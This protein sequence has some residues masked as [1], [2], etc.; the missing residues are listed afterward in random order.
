MN[1]DLTNYFILYA[2]CIPVKGF[3]N[4]IICDVQRGSFKFIPSS[5]FELLQDSKGKTLKTI[6]SEYSREEHE[7]LYEYYDFLIE[8]EFG[9]LTA[10][11]ELFPSITLNYET[12]FLI[13]NAIIDCNCTSSHDFSA[14]FGQ[15]NYLGCKSVQLRFFDTETIDSLQNTIRLASGFTFSIELL[16]KYDTSF[17]QEYLDL[18]QQNERVSSITVHTAD[19]DEILVRG[20]HGVGELLFVKQVIDSAQHCGQI[21]PFL[22]SVNIETFTEAQAFNSCLNKKISIDV[23]GYIRN[24]PSMKS[25]YGHTNDTLLSTVILNDQFT[26]CWT[27]PKDE[28]ESCRDCEFRYICTDCRAFT[29]NP[30]NPYSKP[31][32]CNYDPYKGVWN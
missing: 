23:D 12:P 29:G 27:I 20:D 28:I 17:Q 16:I 14:I 15:L 19:R 22:F 7:T 6:F 21:S 8:N 3:T 31:S 24:C 30:S 25:N 13:S 2:C 4:S 1:L 10:Q 9:F 32:K 5:L 18:L 26:A 11:P